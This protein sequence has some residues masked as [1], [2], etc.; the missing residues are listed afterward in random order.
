M[1]LGAWE[2]TGGTHLLSAM[3]RCSRPGMEE[4][5]PGVL[6]G[7]SLHVLPPPAPT[8]LPP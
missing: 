5:R 6:H 8:W 1:G 3:A 2:G 4:T 7:G